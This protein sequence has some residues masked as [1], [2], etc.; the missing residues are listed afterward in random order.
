MAPWIT[1]IGKLAQALRR[2]RFFFVRPSRCK[3]QQEKTKRDA[4]VQSSDATPVLGRDKMT[5]VGGTLRTV[6]FLL[7]ALSTSTCASEPEDAPEAAAPAKPAENPSVIRSADGREW[8]RL[9]ADGLHDPQNDMLRFLQQ[10]AEALSALPAG[11][12]EGN[13]VDWVAA[14]RQGAIV[15]RTNVFPETKI[16]VIDLDIVFTETAG[17]PFVV[18]PH[19]PHTE[20][21]DC[22][23]CHPAIF[24]A[25]RGANDF[26]MFDVLQGEYCG[27]CH[28]AVS[29]PLTECRRC[30]SRAQQAGG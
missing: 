30:H 14:L 2:L 21:L 1:Y 19:R 15:P 18:F 26:G 3:L 17:Q 6:L 9:A 8:R 13:Q 7:A 12:P 29:F 4:D 20:W 25:K 24:I 11:G 23:N 16:R 27:R 22:A 28:G 5:R 10:P